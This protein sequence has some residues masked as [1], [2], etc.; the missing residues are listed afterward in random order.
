MEARIQKLAEILAPV[1]GETRGRIEK[2]QAQTYEEL[3]VWSGVTGV[4][5]GYR[6]GQGLQVWSEVT[7]VVRGY[8]CGQGLQV[9]SG[10]TGVVR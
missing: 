3:Q 8:R 7:G 5:R 1:V 9:W 10:V 6:C 4:I 2:K